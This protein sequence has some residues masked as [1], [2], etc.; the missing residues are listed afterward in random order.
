MALFE[1]ER[2]ANLASCVAMVEG[3]LTELGHDAAGSRARDADCPQWTFSHGSASVTVSLVPRA[4][5]THLRVVAPVMRTDARVDVL[6]LYRHLLALHA[7]EVHG[8]AFA[9]HRNEI[10]LVAERS[11]IDLDASEVRDVIRRV[12]DYADHYDDKL[13]DEFG[14]RLAGA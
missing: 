14:G 12:R 13:V 6:K 4:D 2:E 10:H 5:F 9:T 1:N 8:A 11:T 3:V 7:T